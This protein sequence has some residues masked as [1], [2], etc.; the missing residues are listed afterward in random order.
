MININ[1]KNFISNFRKAGGCHETDLATEGVGSETG[2]G[3]R[4]S[5]G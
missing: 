4:A 2:V 3:D 1:A 5:E